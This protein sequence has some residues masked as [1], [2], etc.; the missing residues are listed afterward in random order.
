MS[1]SFKGIV[2]GFDTVRY[3]RDGLL[4]A[5]DLVRVI[6]GRDQNHAASMF[7]DLPLKRYELFRIYN[8]TFVFRRFE[9]R[10]GYPTRLVTPQNAISLAKCIHSKKANK[11]V[12]IQI[13]EVI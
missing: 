3:T 6:T 9:G 7:R 1:I 8:V 11:Q 4:F 10:T 2:S 12:R 5:V 13:I